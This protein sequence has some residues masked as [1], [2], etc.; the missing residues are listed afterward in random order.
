[1]QI[2]I[3]H[4]GYHSGIARPLLDYNNYLTTHALDLIIKGLA[5]LSYI[6]YRVIGACH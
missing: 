6:V 4:I 1:M 5:K 3:M 2:I